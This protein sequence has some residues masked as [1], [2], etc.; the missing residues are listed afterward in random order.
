M[1]TY[2]VTLTAPEADARAIAALITEVLDPPPAVSIT[3]EG[4]PRLLEAYFVD[5]PDLDTLRPLVEDSAGADVAAGLELIEIPDENWVVRSQRGL[6]P[7]KAGRFLVYGSHDRAAGKGKRFAMEVDAGQ[8]FGT[9]HHGTTRGCLLAIDRLA[10]RRVHRSNRTLNPEFAAAHEQSECVNARA[11]RSVLDLG[12]GSGV[13]AMAVAKVSTARVLASDIDPI[14][15]DVA[16]ENWRQ[17]GVSAPIRGLVAA[18]LH[19][20]EFARRAPFDLIT[21]NILARPLIKLAPRLAAMAA[22]GGHIVLSGLLDS[23]GREVSATYRQMGMVIEARL[24]LEGWT[25]LILRR[26]GGEG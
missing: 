13:L 22:P 5:R 26:G 1:A 15:V 21:A 25:T 18:G 7:V 19:D 14:A 2:K 24:S 9:A 11:W 17:N 6:H 16:V 12:T 8:A 20:A 3:E 4:T 23:Q 10:K